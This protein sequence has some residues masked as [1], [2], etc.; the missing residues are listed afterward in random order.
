VVERLGSGA[1]NGDGVDEPEG[2][3][4]TPQVGLANGTGDH[5][6][7]CGVADG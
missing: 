6:E 4:K 5:G 7:G 2:A 1:G 3:G